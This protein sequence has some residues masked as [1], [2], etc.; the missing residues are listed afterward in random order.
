MKKTTPPVVREIPKAFPEFGTERQDPWFWLREKE[1]PEVRT[2]VEAENEYFHSVLE[3]IQKI[4]AQFFEELKSLIEPEAIEVPYRNGP[5]EYGSRIPKGAEY[6]VQFRKKL[7]ESN[8]EILLDLNEMAKG[9]NYLSLNEM[10]PSPDHSILAYSL[11]LNG[12]EHDTLYFKDLSQNITSPHTI[13]NVTGGVAWSRDGKFLF[14]TKLNDNDRPYRLYRHALGTDS[15]NDV[16]LYEEL[17][18]RFFLGVRNSKDEKW[19]FL[20]ATAKESSET[21][22]VSTHS[23][24]DE[25]KTFLPRQD[26]HLYALESQNDHF[27]INSNL[28]ER[29][30]KLFEAPVSAKSTLDWKELWSGDAK[31]DLRDLEVFEDHYAIL[32][33]DEGT[34]KISIYSPLHQKQFDLDF[35]E[36]TYS[37]NFVNNVDYNL[38]KLRV[39]YSSFKTPPQTIEY[40]LKTKQKVILRQRQIPDFDPSLYETKKTFAVSHDG[41]RVPISVL[42]RKDCKQP[43]PTLLMG[44]GAYGVPY[45]AAFRTNAIQLVNHGFVFAIAHIRGGGCLGQRWYEEGKFLKKKNSFLDLIA[46]GEG[47]I[48]QNICKKDELSIYG[49]S[50]GGMLVTAAMNLRPDLFKSVEAIVPFVDVMNTMMD[51]T[52]P[53]TPIEFDE[54]GNPKDEKFYHYMLSYSPYDNIEKKAYPHLFMTSGWNDPRVTYWEPA[55]LAAKI[56][57]LRTDKGLTLLRTNLDAGH[58]GLSG[59]FEALKEDAEMNAFLY[60]IHFKPELLGIR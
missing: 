2:Y 18:P 12:S 58:A 30:F 17:D 21:R 36:A 28:G 53:L 40:D 46:C 59:R 48:E 14:Y 15:K 35:D 6:S 1:N 39:I 4:E 47:L 16:L 52:L 54:W 50:A 7:G 10:N 51:E 9:Q 11:D 56:R 41:V 5:W 38:S 19:V 22:F 20:E 32:Y 37:V 8:E 34:L 43:A 42:Y 27:L 44:Y 55:K 45:P 49:G 23:P 33:G 60:A 24:L 31:L 25:L 26:F 57:K 13:T 29:N 3:P